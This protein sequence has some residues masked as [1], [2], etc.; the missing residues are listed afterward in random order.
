MPLTEKET[1][2]LRKLIKER[3]DNYP[4]LDG[5]IA[6]GRLVKKSGWYEA[7]DEHTFNAIIQYATAIEVNKKTGKARIKVAAQSKRLVALSKKL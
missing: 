2:D 1:A 7:L 6:K 3:V 4:D 5:L